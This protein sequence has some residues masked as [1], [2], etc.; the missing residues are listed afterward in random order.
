M[1]LVLAEELAAAFRSRRLLRVM[2]GRELAARNAGAVF[3]RAWVYGQPLLMLAAYFL[4]FDV[5]LGARLGDVAPRRGMGVFL[6]AGMLP[7]MAFTDAI[8]RAM[9]SLVDAGSL[10]QKNPL[11]PVLFPMRSVL[12]SLT[13]YGPLMLLLWLAYTPYH[14]FAWPAL[15]LPLLVL[16]QFA[17]IFVLGYLLAVMVAA[18]RDVQQ[19]V[20]FLLAAGLFLTPILFSFE[21][22][23]ESF[24]W[25][26]WLNPMTPIVLGFQALLLHGMWPVPAAFLA[27]VAWFGMLG[28]ML[29][30][31]VERSHDQLVDWL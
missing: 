28:L 5:I 19:F 24:R 26:L 27:L 9:T 25:I 11:P 12:A 21:M 14:R 2:V 13:T 6:I 23:P 10:L 8:S 20:G 18:M 3:G 15:A 22:F 30:V 17:L 1:T 4:L 31:A 16:V 29:A 7:W